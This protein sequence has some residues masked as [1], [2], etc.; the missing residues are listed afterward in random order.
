MPVEDSVKIKMTGEDAG[1]IAAWKEAAKGPEKVADAMEKMGRKGKAANDSL[2][3][4][5]EAT[6]AKFATGAGMIGLAQK[7]LEFYMETNRRFVQEGKEATKTIDESFR[8]FQIVADLRTSGMSASTAKASIS[9]SAIGA[10]VPFNFASAAA[11]QATGSGFGTKD[12]LQRGGLDSLLQFAVASGTA[13]EDPNEQV[14]S[15]A[16]AMNAMGVELTPENMRKVLVA[17]QQQSKVGNMGASSLPLLAREASQIKNFG[18]M[19]WQDSIAVM[20]LLQDT[21]SP[22]KAASSFRGTVSD[23]ATLG[24]DP[25]KVKA[26]SRAG[27]KPGQVDLQGETLPQVLDTLHGAMGKMSAS[28]KIL[29]LDTI[30]K[31]ESMPGF[32]ALADPKNRAKLAASYGVMVNEAGFMEDFRTGSSGP[33][34]EMRRNE[35][36]RMVAMDKRGFGSVAVANDAM[37]AASIEAGEA[38]TVTAAKEIVAE[39]LAGAGV[40]GNSAA[41]TANSGINLGLGASGGLGA[42]LFNFVFKDEDNRAMPVEQR[43]KAIEDQSR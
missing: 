14:K 33:A 6:F 32:M 35:T 1:A 29:F 2:G 11:G 20:S 21:L 26:L 31:Q 18:N 39:Q 12:V 27:L 9:K 40:R 13:N 19:K 37:A 34:A 42:M 16:L 24:N 5:L 3:A 8:R 43:G 4:S 38:P 41:R 30:I 36:R 10:S 23:L 15:I 25:K 22:E 7:A 28:E 17:V